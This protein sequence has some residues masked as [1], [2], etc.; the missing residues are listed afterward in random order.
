MTSRM[1]LTPQELARMIDISALRLQHGEREILRMVEHARRHRFIAV[2]VL[3]AWVG[4]LP[5]DRLTKAFERT[6]TA[7]AEIQELLAG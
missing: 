3:P 2:H 4:F 6:R 1:L 7:A 5:E